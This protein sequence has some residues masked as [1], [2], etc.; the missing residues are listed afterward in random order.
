MS[1]YKVQ[2]EAIEKTVNERKLELAKID[3]QKSTAKEE[4]TKL[5]AELTACG[6][7][8]PNTLPAFIENKK[9]E[10]STKLNELSGKLGI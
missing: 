3:Q 10:L 9:T 4:E 7:T 2:L 6:I 5:L 1:D 8:D